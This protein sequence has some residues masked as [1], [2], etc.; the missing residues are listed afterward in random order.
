MKIKLNNHF[1]DYDIENVYKTFLT[2]EFHLFKS[3]ASGDKNIEVL[4]CKTDQD[5]FQ[6]HLGMGNS[7]I[8]YPK[9]CCHFY[10]PPLDC[11]SST[12]ENF[13]LQPEPMCLHRMSKRVNRPV[14]C[15]PCIQENEP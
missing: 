6:N 13:L 14:S 15:S 3:H 11:D 4:E 10:R 2:E 5:N 8:Y 1:K 12:K 9:G 7:T